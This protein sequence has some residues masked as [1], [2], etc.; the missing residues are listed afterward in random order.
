MDTREKKQVSG[1]TQSENLHVYGDEKLITKE[2]CTELISKKKYSEYFDIVKVSTEKGN[3][4]FL[5]LGVNAVSALYSDEDAYKLEYVAGQVLDV[6]LGIA[7]TVNK[8]ENN[9]F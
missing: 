3:R 6:M 9:K 7:L 5:A 2:N 8:V 4:N 1:G